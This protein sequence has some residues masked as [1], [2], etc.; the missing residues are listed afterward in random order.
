MSL[1]G[2]CVERAIQDEPP[3]LVV[4][5]TVADAT[6]NDPTEIEPLYSVIDPDALDSLFQTSPAGP[7]RPGGQVSFCLER[8]DV[9]VH[10]DRKVV[11][12]PPGADEN[13]ERTGDTS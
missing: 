2:Y 9:V 1:E 4:I 3:S 11:V 7:L 13:T 10:G 6:D 8:C 5:S 12:K